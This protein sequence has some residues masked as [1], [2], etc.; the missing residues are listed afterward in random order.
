M[1]KFLLGI[2]L[3]LGALA[4]GQSPIINLD[5][6][7]RDD[8]TGKKLAGAKVE[9]LQDGK[10]FANGTAASNGKVP[11][12]DLPIGHTYTVYIKKDGYVTKMTKVEAYF[13]YPED[14][15]PFTL[16]TFE[17]SIFKSVEGIDFKFLETTPMAE[18]AMDAE[19]F[20][21]Y[22]KVKV[23]EMLAKIEKLKKQMAEKQEE[24][25]KEE[26][27]AAQREADFLEYV[28]AGDLAVSKEEFDKGIGQY[29]LALAIKTDNQE[30]KDKIAAA[31]KKLEDLKNSAE[32]DKLFGEKMTAAKSAYSA[33]KLEEALSL[34]KEA[35][36]IKPDEKQP[37]DLIKEIEDLLAEQ[38]ATKEAFEKLVA[39]G[40]AAVG[41]KKFDDAIA[42]YK[43]AIKIKADPAV[44][45]KIT[46]A[47][48]AKAAQE[49]ANA[50]SKKVD[51]EY[52][53]ILAKA[54]GAL[55]SENYEEA[56]TNYEAALKLKPGEP[57]PTI[58]L[59][60]VNKI[61]AKLAAEN[62]EKEKLEA[63]YKKLIDEGAAFVKN[64]EFEAAIESYKAALGVKENDQHA[65]DQLDLINK[66]KLD[67]EANAK[68][69]AEYKAAIEEG[70]K[71]AELKEYQEAINAYT[72]A[73]D[74]K[75]KEDEPK[76]KIK[77]LEKLLEGAEKEAENEK[78]YLEF[79]EA[80]NSALS[81]EAYSDAIDKF[82]KALEVR[83]GDEVAQKEIDTINKL[84]VEKK[85]LAEEQEKFDGFVALGAEAFNAK[86]LDAA[87]L[88]YNKALE[89]REDAEVKAKVEE[90]EKLIAE[91]Q[92]EAEQQAKYD[93]AIKAAEEFFTANDYTPALENFEAA[94]SIK[95]TPEVDKRI[96]ETKRLLLE[97]KEKAAADS[98][99][100]A[101]LDS[102]KEQLAAKAYQKAL[103]TY[104]EAYKL[105][106]EPAVKDEID[107]IQLILEDEEKNAEKNAAYEAKIVEADLKFNDGNLEKAKA[108]YA[109]AIEINN[110]KPYPSDQIVKI[111]KLMQDETSAEEE[112]KYQKIIAKADGLRD[113]EK[114]DDAISYYERAL[115]F[116]SED[117]Y[118]K[119]EIEKIN[120]LKKDLADAEAKAAKLEE[121]YEAFI[122]D[123]DAAYDTES[124][125]SAAEKYKAALELK[126]GEE[127]PTERL[128]ELSGKLSEAEK[129]EKLEA[130]YKAIIEKADTA[131]ETQQYVESIN[132][133]NQSFMLKKDE[134]YP[135][136]Q[137]EKAEN[138]LKLMNE[139]DADAAYNKL[140][141]DGEAKFK[142]NE[143]EAALALF[144]QA[145]T[146][147]PEDPLPE[148]RINEIN[149]AIEK[150][151]K[152][153]L[154]RVEFEALKVEAD[155]LF[156]QSEWAK[157]KEKY[158]RAYNLI[159]EEYVEKQ[160]KIC[161][162]S[163]QNVTMV[164]EDAQYANILNAA[165]SKFT[166]QDYIKA[167]ELYNRALSFKPGDQ[168]PKDQLKLIEQLLNPTAVAS[169]PQLK[170]YGKANRQTNAVDIGALLADAEEQRKFNLTQKVEQQRLEASEAEGIDAVRQRD[171]NFTTRKKAI[172][173][174]DNIITSDDAA[175]I[176][177]EEASDAVEVALFE[178]SIVQR[179]RTT[180]NEN[181]IQR[182]NQV[183]TNLKIAIDEKSEN[184]DLPREE[185]LANVERIH[186]E[187]IN[188]TKS[189]SN[190]Q[191]NE[192][193]EQ[194]II[195]E[196]EDIERENT[197]VNADLE[198]KNTELKVENYNVDLINTSN[199]LLWNQEDEILKIKETKEDDYTKIINLEKARDKERID[200]VELVDE[201]GVDM[202]KTQRNSND[203]HYEVSIEQKKYSERI[204]DE[205]IIE[206]QLNDIPREQME[207]LVEKQS[208]KNEYKTINLGLD[209]ENESYNTEKSLEDLAVTVADR[210][211]AE[212]KRR[213]GYEQTVD[214]IKE[215][216]RDYQ[217]DKIAD[218]Y[219]D[220][221]STK[222]YIDGVEDKS[223][224]INNSAD[225]KAIENVDDTQDKLEEMNDENRDLK[226][227][228]DNTVE[229]TEKYLESLRDIDVKKIDSAMKN[230]L[231]NQFPEGV[232]EEIFTTND[233]DGLI[234][235][236]IIRRVV[237]RNG[238]GNVY[239]KIQT[240]YG[241]SSYTVNG[242]G[243]AEY[244]WQD[245]TEAADLIRN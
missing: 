40:D 12:I 27:A 26:E 154:V 73:S 29:E 75:P 193:M 158:V 34:Y 133:Y 131:F 142:A 219:D 185:Y 174:E 97:A 184:S 51:K 103:E 100:T 126:P 78:K 83:P 191:T 38:K 189:A 235:S 17:T 190:N 218:G 214:A 119:D 180:D 58:E 114:W 200:N 216:E 141:S 129:L 67:Y 89:V 177:I 232:T 5:V 210:E 113:D 204:A 36:G 41:A 42:K 176:K 179:E 50:N 169:S 202:D 96:E 93:A 70:A 168:F 226:E 1:K 208:L 33:N 54:R 6:I 101:I 181:A 165:N 149:Q 121:D 44:D 128:E 102:A 229:E 236:Y 2:F 116:R 35:S 9:V 233:E 85:K 230:E 63:E 61:L 20:I 244:Q 115:S 105:R 188:E 228:N 80:G 122:R 56:K 15:Q 183:V 207:D 243:I 134:A 143:F 65:L 7:L 237:V 77:Q 221:H 109:E 76:E 13:D 10:P 81:V 30:V 92:N 22:D 39:E 220:S 57:I 171:D 217:R 144:T 172:E 136:S 162:E 79:M 104:R 240:K 163:M 137:I 205:M 49:V 161:D 68:I 166:A 24:L 16:L 187:L 18:F 153:A 74:I 91:S 94:K 164:E 99:Y 170:N 48:A 130:E 194:K 106:P 52:N 245:E 198:R 238:E 111:D 224:S 231:G 4:F 241:T 46:D 37:K 186:V 206:N 201:I 53:D 225:K 195:I 151:A 23:K 108:L 59:E 152:D 125:S 28:K 117:P 118:P 199:Q 135:T 19:G 32:K 47:E 110:T 197:F 227:S 178:S 123:G 146:E 84:L 139:N 239:E 21:G 107:K 167:K 132:L 192:V 159:N 156:E 234:N 82:T 127:H 8:D 87:K 175:T 71:F 222:D 95:S 211:K 155:N 173:I 145:N 43:A 60:D 182:Q 86:N 215:N 148:R 242:V 90:I 203:D 64:N 88:N 157:A 45:K 120:T 138:L 147:K 62:A 66:A 213:E 72:K 160:I 55:D 25:A 11:M 3:M 196:K 14:L 98:E 124:W 223:I 209:Q 31:K 212:Q 69:N 140:L 112:K 150:A